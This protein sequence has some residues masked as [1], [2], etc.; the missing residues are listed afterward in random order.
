MRSTSGGLTTLFRVICVVSLVLCLV[1]AAPAK[2]LHVIAQT[3]AVTAPIQLYD[4]QPS[5]DFIV[6]QSFAN[7]PQH[8][9]GPLD[10]SID[11]ASNTLFITYGGS[12]IIEIVNADTMTAI[13]S[14]VAPGTMS[15]AGIEVDQ[16]N[17]LVYTMGRGTARFYV[18]KWNPA[19]KTL[20]L[21]TDLFLPGVGWGYGIALDELNDLLYVADYSSQVVRYFRTSDWTQAGSFVVSQRPMGIAVDVSSG[22]V[23]TGNASP[24]YGSQQRLSKYNLNTNTEATLY[25]PNVTKNL[26]D[27]V[28]GLAVDQ[29]SGLLYITTGNQVS[30]GSDRLVVFDSAFN[31]LKS[32]GDIGD[33]AGLCVAGKIVSYD[34]LFLSQDDGL[35][36]QCVSSGGTISYSICYDNLANTAD[37]HD[38]TLV[39]VLAENVSFVS[40]SDGGVYDP[41]T[42]KVTWN[43]GTLP[44]GAPRKCV[45]LVVSV[46]GGAQG[47]CSLYNHCAISG[48][49][50]GETAAVQTS[51][52]V[53]EPVPATK[54]DEGFF[55]FNMGALKPIVDGAPQSLCIDVALKAVL[56]DEGKQI[57]DPV[58]GCL[59]MD[60]DW[61]N[62]NFMWRKTN[63]Y[64]VQSVTLEKTHGMRK[65]ACNM[66]WSRDS[67]RQ[68]GKE[69]ATSEINLCWPLL[70]E[71][72]GT[73]WVLS[74]VYQTNPAKADPDGNLARVH[75]ERYVWTVDWKA[76]DFSEFRQRLT[77]FS[78]MPAGA[79]ELLAVPPLQLRKM[80]W[81]LDGYG[82]P[83]FNS[84]D[85]G[86][87]VLLNT[88]VP[89]DLQR[90]A[91]KVAQ[92]ENVIDQ[93]SC[94]E[95]CN[96]DCSTWPSLHAVG[97][98][99]N[100]TS[101][102]GSVL[103]TDLYY[104]AHAAGLL[105]D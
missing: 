103:L 99:N 97:I 49:E 18:F 39:D 66:V 25:L 3:N 41:A 50:T 40:A 44:A 92:L 6:Y 100:C 94:I 77:L 93:D 28:V 63:A 31:M 21:Q 20:T 54:D 53:C 22:L 11:T 34:P 12:N 79:C 46:D 68:Q 84:W 2:S 14:A 56:D 30:G 105:G 45:S 24:S 10:V 55:V 71:T 37:V 58:T 1:T 78:H 67:I 32:T 91:N 85:P 16:D 23:Y 8:N 59:A 80:L 75:K 33:P 29:D 26:S 43:I 42:R 104:A 48:K 9:Q 87:T 72:E 19:A 13:G 47:G 88:G 35:G 70:Y 74:L 17:G 65:G 69:L 51:S 52:M 61:T 4:I 96:Y 98:L 62:S 101:P 15:L 7:V 73:Q 90:A 95:L 86:I 64:F 81:L 27:H 5:P 36:G 76:A 60:Y 38:V 83:K 82:C 89:E 102:M 57:L